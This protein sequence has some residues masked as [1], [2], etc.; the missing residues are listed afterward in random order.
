[1]NFKK[2]RNPNKNCTYPF[3]DNPLGYCWSYACYIDGDERFK[4][5]KSICKGCD[6]W[7][8]KKKGISC[9]KKK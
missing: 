9:Q 1:M 3:E 4:N 2:Y 6:Y 8:I 7:T 5:I